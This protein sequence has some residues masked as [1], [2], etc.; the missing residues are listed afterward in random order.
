MVGHYQGAGHARRAIQ[1]GHPQ[2]RLDNF[3]RCAKVESSRWESF[4]RW[5]R[6][7]HLREDWAGQNRVGGAHH[8]ALQH[9]VP[10]AADLRHDGPAAW[11]ELEDG[12]RAAPQQLVRLPPLE[13][14]RAGRRRAGAGPG[15]AARARWQCA[16]PWRV[17]QWQGR[18]EQRGSLR[19][20]YKGRHRTAHDA[21]EADPGARGAPVRGGHE[22]VPQHHPGGPD[23]V[24]E[25]DRAI[26]EAGPE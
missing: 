19:D 15:G 11:R 1:Q 8:H 3:F 9:A 5:W 26:G 23:Y 2:H 4:R 13:R 10:D 21:E 6:R 12:D 17:A 20:R 14:V 24:L 16:C 18:W 22:P 7:G 25:H